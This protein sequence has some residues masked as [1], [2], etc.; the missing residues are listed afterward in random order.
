VEWWFRLRLHFQTL[1]SIFVEM[2]VEV[3]DQQDYDQTIL[4]M[5]SDEDVSD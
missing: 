2:V 1:Y 5:I 4:V 3:V